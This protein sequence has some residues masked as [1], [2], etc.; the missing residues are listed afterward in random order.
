MMTGY[1][2][3]AR[4]VEARRAGVSEFL[5]KPITAKGVLDRLAVTVLKP[6]P[7]VVA[8]TYIGPDRR[9]AERSE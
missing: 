5:V 8:K 9:R 1:A 6:R 7:V 4:V 3:R 2:D